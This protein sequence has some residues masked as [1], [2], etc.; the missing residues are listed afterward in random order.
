MGC[1]HPEGGS[2]GY[3]QLPLPGCRMPAW[4]QGQNRGCLGARVTQRPWRGEGLGSRK[5]PCVREWEGFRA[6]LHGPRV[7]QDSR[8]RLPQGPVVSLHRPRLRSKPCCHVSP[9]PGADPRSRPC[10]ECVTSL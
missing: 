2:E 6:D 4:R 10:S 1:G 8:T 7:T 3:S 5:A 9:D